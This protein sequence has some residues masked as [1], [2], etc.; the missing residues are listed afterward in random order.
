MDINLKKNP[1][2]LKEE[3]SN[4]SSA[5]NIADLFEIPYKDLIYYLYRLPNEKKYYSFEIQKKNGETRIISTPTTSIKILQQKLNYIL[6]IIFT[7][8]FSS[9]GF[10]KGKSIKTNASTHVKLSLIHI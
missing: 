1:E 7:P 2:Q 9:H 6:S 10:V 8:K 4:L 5:E 3:F